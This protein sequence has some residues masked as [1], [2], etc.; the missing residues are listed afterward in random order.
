M[1]RNLWKFLALIAVLSFLTVSVISCGDDNNNNNNNNN[2]GDDGIFNAGSGS[3]VLFDIRSPYQNVNWGAYGQF[4]AAYHVHTINSDGSGTMEQIIQLHYDLD[5]DIL[6][7]TDHV[8]AEAHARRDPL[9]D[10]PGAPQRRYF[11]LINRCVTNETWTYGGFTYNLTHITKVQLDAFQAGTAPSETRTV[12]RGILMIPG[13]AELAPGGDPTPDEV[14]VFFYPDDKLPPN[15]WAVQLREGLS[16]VN[17]VGALGVINHPGRSTHAMTFAQ[18]GAADPENPSNQGRWIRRYANLFMEFPITNI[19]GIEIINRR[20]V[21]SR[22]DRVLWDNIN[23]L[24]IPQGRFVW[25]FGGDDLHSTSVSSTGNG[26]HISY[27]MML[28]PSNTLENYR[29]A[30]VNGQFYIVTVAAFNEGVN[31][32]ATTPGADRPSIN[33]ITF[34]Q[35]ADTIT[36]SANNA[37]RIVWLSEGKVIHEEHDDFSTI[38]L[39][40]PA[41]IDNVGAFVRANIFGP[42]GLAM[43]QPIATTRK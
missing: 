8:W 12:D 42:G 28:M 37:T 13:T 39:A 41:I 3:G 23:A 2:N 9:N 22:H 4:K 5:Y 25:G 31:L 29:H 14:N 36:I 43:T 17:E 16:H 18:T 40:S 33:S 15:A 6:P 32:S 24:T 27:N 19:L 20:D 7:I 30:M 38:N 11:N 26:V 10:P 34:S 1:K 35:T 21:D